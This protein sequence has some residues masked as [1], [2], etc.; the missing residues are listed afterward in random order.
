MLRAIESWMV[1]VTLKKPSSLHFRVFLAFIVEDCV[2][3][4]KKIYLKKKMSCSRSYYDLGLI[5]NVLTPARF[6][7]EAF[8]VWLLGLAHFF[9][10]TSLK[11]KPNRS[12]WDK[13]HLL[14]LYYKARLFCG[15]Q[16]PKQR[17]GYLVVLFVSYFQLSVICWRDRPNAECPL[18]LQFSLLELQ[19]KPKKSSRTL[20]I[21]KQVQS[22]LSNKTISC[23]R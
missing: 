13:V 20:N 17:L 4:T 21:S 8:V 7:M 2:N 19:P 16:L 12:F 9:L 5:D 6:F 1:S 23:L 14:W 11:L 22:L 15:L 18:L 10:R 3:L